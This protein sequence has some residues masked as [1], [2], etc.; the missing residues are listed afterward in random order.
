MGGGFAEEEEAIQSGADR[1]GAEAGG[2][3]RT[4]GWN[5]HFGILWEN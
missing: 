4:C 3:G 1:R 5:W 2:C